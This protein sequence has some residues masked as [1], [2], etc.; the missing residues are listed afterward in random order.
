MSRL[1]AVVVAGAA[2]AVGAAGAQPSVSPL[3]IPGGPPPK[4]VASYPANGGQAPG[5]VIVLKITFDQPMTA[6]AWSYARADG[7]DFPQ[8]LE[9]PRLLADKKTFVLLCTV[10]QGAAYA[11]SVNL[12]PRFA[13]ANGR[14]AEPYVLKFST[15]SATEVRDMH[16]ALTQAGLTDADEPVMSW[17]DDGKGVSETP[18]AAP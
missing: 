4:V 3:V 9:R 6:D 13:S 2:L 15:N 1:A 5:G 18:A 11:L 17:K 7:G 14:S 10:Q 8:C 12:A 16:T